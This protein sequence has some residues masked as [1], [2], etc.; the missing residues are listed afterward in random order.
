[1]SVAALL[2]L[3]VGSV[4]AVSCK[5]PPPPCNPD[6]KNFK[7]F[8]LVVQPELM[9][10]D[11]EGNPR[12][13]VLRV[14]QLKG[15]RTLDA[16][17]FD[18]VFKTP[19]DF[20]GDELMGQKEL[21]VYPERPEVI[22]I[23]IVPE[24]THVVAVALFRE[25]TGNTWYSEWEVPMFHGYSVCNAETRKQ[26]KWEDPCFYLT[27]EG[28]EVDGGHEPPPAFDPD[29]FEGLKCPP[30]PLK[31]QPPLE[32]GGKKKKKR[33]KRNAKEDAAKAQEGGEKAQGGADKAQGGAD[34]AGEAGDK[35]GG[36]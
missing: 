4:A 12:T 10:M 27:I 18:T 9:N 15:G 1:M 2:A 5:K 13:T 21:P 25:P 29:K 7:T 20:F 35:V 31:V 32:T 34:K 16:M 6:E 19:E 11:D 24:A 36:K 30:K 33:K 28:T 23:D 26:P 8:R 17:D 14:Y 3:G 22:D